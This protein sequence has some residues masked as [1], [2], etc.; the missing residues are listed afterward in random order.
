M[1]PSF[2]GAFAEAGSDLRERS[3]II[4]IETF[5]VPIY[6]A[7]L[8][9]L[10]RKIQYNKDWNWQDSTIILFD[11]L[12]LR[13]RSSII[14]IETGSWPG[15]CSDYQHLRERS[16]IIRIETTGMRRGEILGLHLRE[17]SSII[18]IETHPT[19]PKLQINRKYLRERS[20][21]IRIETIK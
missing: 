15:L 17:R 5:Y 8:P 16:S 6:Q 14:R 7:Y 4:R 18:R 9:L 3:S 19:K 2:G 11:L 20:S 21:I 1:K 13:E 10:K 12:Y